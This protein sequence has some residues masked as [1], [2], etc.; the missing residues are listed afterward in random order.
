VK[1]DAWCEVS[2]DG[3]MKGR[4]GA[5]PIEVTAGPHT[6]VCEQTGMNRSWTTKV[7]VVGGKTAV[8]SGSILGTVTVTLGV[9]ASIDGKAYTSGQTIQL[10]AAR[11]Q[12]QVGDSRKHVSITR[13]CQIRSS[14]E[15]GCF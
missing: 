7:T 9:D 10:K 8:A 12:V 5:T 15:I 6:V 14:P 3:E 13:P 1:T 4:A 11:Y 2:I